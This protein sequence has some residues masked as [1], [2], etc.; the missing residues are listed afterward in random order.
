M[1][2]CKGLLTP[3]VSSP[4]LVRIQ[5]SPPNMQHRNIS[6]EDKTMDIDDFITI[7]PALTA[8]LANAIERELRALGDDA[9]ALSWF[10]SDAGSHPLNH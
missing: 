3:R 7:R 1:A 9:K 5:P 4:S 8:A 6:R 2:E 10:S